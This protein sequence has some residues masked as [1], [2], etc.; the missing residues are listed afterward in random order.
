MKLSRLIS[1]V[2]SALLTVLML[3]SP[4]VLASSPNLVFREIKITGD[5]FIILQNIGDA[6][7]ADMSDYWLGY[8]GS[9]SAT[10]PPYQ[11]LPAVALPAQKAILLSGGATTNTCDAYLVSDLSP[12]LSDS[13][14]TLNLW[15]E[16]SGNFTLLTEPQAFA[17]WVK[18]TSSHQAATGE[19]NLKVETDQYANPVWFYDSGW[20]LASLD[21]C[22]LTTYS[23]A[24]DTTGS[25]AVSW[26]ENS[27]DPPSVIQSIS[28]SSASFYGVPPSDI[29]QKPPVINELLPN[30]GQADKG[31]FIE[32][33]NPNSK[34]FDLQN[35]VLQTGTTTLHKYTFPSGVTL[36][37]NSFTAFLTNGTG[38]SLVNSGGRA[39]LI[40]PNGKVLSKSNVYS[41]AKAGQA[42]ALANGVW[43]WTVSPTPS[44]ENVINQLSSNIS[45][46]SQPQVLGANTSSAGGSNPPSSNSVGSSAAAEPI[47][48]GMLAG[49]GA[50]AVGYAMYEYRSDLAN[51]YRKFQQYREARAA[52]GAKLARRGSAGAG[53]GPWW[54]Q[55][56]ISDWAGKRYAKLR[57]HK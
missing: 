17:F 13:Q 53:G 33:Y 2:V 10:A 7:V 45:G 20:Q 34:S 52:A 16:T 54:W 31:E 22:S 50:L 51:G 15:Q 28:S 29:G 8:T 21:N 39:E 42:W 43:Y 46:G 41:S 30:P 49:V 27:S 18:E 56:N 4:K 9:D 37:P 5:E 36:K 24:S 26:P 32:L 6:D 40:D 12:N 47:H 44:A 48:K 14:G 11:Q 38:L 3:F 19:I 35:F 55:N 23:S 57:R 25:Q 1:G